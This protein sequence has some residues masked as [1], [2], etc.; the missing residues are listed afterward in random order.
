MFDCKIT[1]ISLCAVAYCVQ[2]VG[3]GISIQLQYVEK[4]VLC[5]VILKR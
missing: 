3:Q 4:I 1:K 5:H 2:V